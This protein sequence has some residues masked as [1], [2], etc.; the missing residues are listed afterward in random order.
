MK[1]ITWDDI[2]EI[3]KA[4]VVICSCMNLNLSNEDKLLHMV[5][6]LHRL[7]VDLRETA[8]AEKMNSVP[9]VFKLLKGE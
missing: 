5:Y 9:H 7:L 8:I 6:C 1:K 4:D 3:A 2:F